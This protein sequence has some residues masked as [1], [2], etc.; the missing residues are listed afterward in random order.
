MPSILL[1]F[2]YSGRNR[3][4]TGIWPVSG[5]SWNCSSWASYSKYLSSS[6]SPQVHGSCI[7]PFTGA[8]VVTQTNSGLCRSTWIQP[9]HQDSLSWVV[10]GGDMWGCFPTEAQ[11][12][13]ASSPLMLQFP[14]CKTGLVVMI[15]TVTLR[16]GVRIKQ[17]DIR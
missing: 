11:F 2:L 17:A 6:G 13:Q 12:K 9:S 8:R 15:L 10:M 3:P 14:S 16:K 5:T 7:N 4:R 1:S